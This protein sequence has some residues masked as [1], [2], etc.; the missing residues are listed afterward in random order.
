MLTTARSRER[1]PRGAPEGASPADTLTLGPSTTLGESQLLLFTPGLCFFVVMALRH[2][3]SSWPEPLGLRESPCPV[4]YHPPGPLEAPCVP[5]S[6][7][8][9]VPLPDGLGCKGHRLIRNAFWEPTARRWPSLGTTSTSTPWESHCQAPGS[10][11]RGILGSP[12][13]PPAPEITSLESQVTLTRLP[14]LAPRVFFPV[15]P[16]TPTLAVAAIA[17]L[18]LPGA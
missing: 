13:P 7:S 2:S 18:D 15:P 9:N 10:P 17:N 8:L 14:P 11:T 12:S 4:A 16:P 6:P 5:W 3:H 1:T